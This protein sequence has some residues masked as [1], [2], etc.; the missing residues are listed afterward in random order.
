MPKK[1]TRIT[2]VR[3]ADEA[4]TFSQ[5]R[6][7]RKSRAGARSNIRRDHP[8]IPFA[9]CRCKEN[10]AAGGKAGAAKAFSNGADVPPERD[11]NRRSFDRENCRPP[12]APPNSN[13][14]YVSR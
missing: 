6:E 11:S 5:R 3:S 9:K 13:S 1:T 4:R 7:V 10:A 12:H 2:R 8:E 14:D